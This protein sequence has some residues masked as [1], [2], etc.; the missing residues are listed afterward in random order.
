MAAAYTF[1][2]LIK[3]VYDSILTPLS[4]LLVGVAVVLFFLGLVRYIYGGLG[5][6]SA[7][8]EAKSMMIWGVVIIFMMI[9]IWGFVEI[10]QYTFFGGAVTT[11]PDIPQL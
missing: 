7:V 11:P 10:L 4:V 6:E 1:G 5:D 8:R 9:S 2:E 3:N